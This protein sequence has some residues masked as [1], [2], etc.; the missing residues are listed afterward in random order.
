MRYFRSLSTSAQTELLLPFKL[1][2]SGNTNVWWLGREGEGKIG[3]EVGGV[4]A[5]SS[6]LKVSRNPK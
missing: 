1:L 5:K 4:L 2:P 3:R 6:F